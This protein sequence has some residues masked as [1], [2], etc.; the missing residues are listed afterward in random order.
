M[1]ENFGAADLMEVFFKST[2]ITKYKQK[3]GNHRLNELLLVVVV[4]V[5]ELLLKINKNFFLL[6]LK[7]TKIQKHLVYF[8]APK[9]I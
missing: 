5:R 3:K 4:N 7:S 8:G 6:F 1:R 9:A 2:K